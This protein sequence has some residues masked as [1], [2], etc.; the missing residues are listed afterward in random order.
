MRNSGRKPFDAVQFFA[1]QLPCMI[2]GSLLGT[3]GAVAII[4]VLGV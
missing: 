2:F 1:F 3:L 4:Q